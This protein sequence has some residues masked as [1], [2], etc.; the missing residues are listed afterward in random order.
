[1]LSA[2][3]PLLVA[4]RHVDFLRIRSSLCLSGR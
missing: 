2:A 3:D 4:R 1:V